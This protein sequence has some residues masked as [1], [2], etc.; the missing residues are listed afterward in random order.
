M[1]TTSTPTSEPVKAGAD[2]IADSK[3]G[4]ALPRA[5]SDE[6]HDKI[7][8]KIDDT[9][10]EA[11]GPPDAGDA[12]LFPAATLSVVEKNAIVHMLLNDEP[13][14]LE[15]YT[16]P[17]FMNTCA[18]QA[19]NNFFQRVLAR[20]GDFDAIAEHL[21]ILAKEEA[22]LD[23]KFIKLMFRSPR[24]DYSMDVIQMWVNIMIGA[25]KLKLLDCNSSPEAEAEVVR[26]IDDNAAILGQFGDIDGGHWKV[27]MLFNGDANRLFESD[28]TEA[29]PTMLNVGVDAINKDKPLAE[30]VNEAWTK[31]WDQ[32]T[33]ATSWGFPNLLFT[34]EGLGSQEEL[35]IV[36]QFVGSMQRGQLR[37][38]LEAKRKAAKVAKKD[39]AKSAVAAT[40]A[41][42][43]AK[44][45]VAATA[46]EEA[47][48]AAETAAEAEAEAEAAEAAAKAE[49]EAEAAEA[50][51]EA[52]VEAATA[53][54]VTA[55]EAEL[56][57]MAAADAADAADVAA[58][59][60]AAADVADVA[61]A[62]AAVAAAD[63][64]DAAD[65]A[66]ATAAAVEADVQA[67]AES[68]N[69][70]RFAH[71]GVCHPAQIARR[72]DS[73]APL[74]NVASACA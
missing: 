32:E 31:M 25:D 53:A 18:I 57:A 15:H 30:L 23:R 4:A 34:I 13:R 3:D 70:V 54:H 64:A 51:A 63:A 74:V 41:E 61:D 42:E 7:A 69:A 36:E 1:A 59:A 2:S 66:A 67:T 72:L 56:E 14:S 50:A 58:A 43:A 73:P 37:R 46:A 24:G 35:D 21:E 44:E 52:E 22:D 10:V 68:V 33:Q 8:T 5:V 29:Y 39:A 55:A 45:A 11:F 62:A 71:C 20:R 47:M 9:F 27:A 48:T 40:A 16:Q 38:T 6:L 19:L 17:K 65:V 49:V 60:V 12:H 26:A 28:S